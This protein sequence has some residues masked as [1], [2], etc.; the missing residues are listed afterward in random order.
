MIPPSGSGRSATLPATTVARRKILELRTLSAVLRCGS[1]A[2]RSVR[3][4]RALSKR[5]SL[6]ALSH[7][8]GL[9]RALATAGAGWQDAAMHTVTIEEAVA[10]LPELIDEAC[11]G[12]EVVIA[13]A[14]ANAVR[15]TPIPPE[16]AENREHASLIGL[17]KGKI[18]FHEGWEE[19]PEEFKPYMK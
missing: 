7:L 15:L 2:A 10:H 17:L 1:I 11:R 16:P 13:Q 3:I 5:P 8:P 4:E 18:V 19:T 6:G 14:G 12:G 9:R